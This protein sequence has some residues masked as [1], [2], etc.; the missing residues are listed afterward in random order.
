[1]GSFLCPNAANVEPGRC[2]KGQHASKKTVTRCAN[3]DCREKPEICEK[4][5]FLAR[6]EAKSLLCK[7]CY[8]A[9]Q[10]QDVSDNDDDSLVRKSTPAK[11]QLEYSASRDPSKLGN[12]GHAEAGGFRVGDKANEEKIKADLRNQ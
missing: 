4:C 3:E 12:Q 1:M 5:G 7:L 9:E 8:C 2:E 11:M 10:N 6:A